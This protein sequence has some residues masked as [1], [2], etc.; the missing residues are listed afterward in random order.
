MRINWQAVSDAHRSAVIEALNAA[1]REISLMS[2]TF[3]YAPVNL[4]EEADA[5]MAELRASQDEVQA[6]IRLNNHLDSCAVANG[7]ALNRGSVE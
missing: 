4:V 7:V 1:S 5:L 2:E 3:T 6:R